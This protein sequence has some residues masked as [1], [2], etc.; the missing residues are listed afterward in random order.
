MGNFGKIGKLISSVPF[1]SKIGK[2][3]KLKLMIIFGSAAEG[4]THK[5]S[6]IDVAVASDK[7]IAYKTFF[8]I[9]SDLNNIFPD[10]EVDLCDL[11]K[12]SPLLLKKI[13]DN[14]ILV[15]GKKRDFYN[16]KIGAFKSYV[17]YLP[18]FRIEEKSVTKFI[19]DYA[20]R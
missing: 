3:Y 7:N 6:D 17:D 14:G 9:C 20:R 8:G 18:Y 15:Y 5:T 2:K 4:K 19:S 13:S 1:I 12:V 10:K 11:K 16:F